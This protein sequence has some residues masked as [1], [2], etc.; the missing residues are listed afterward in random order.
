MVTISFFYD[1]AHLV[2]KALDDI[3]EYRIWVLRN[4]KKGNRPLP[5]YLYTE[6]SRYEG[7]TPQSL[8]HSPYLKKFGVETKLKKP[9][10]EPRIIEEGY[11]T[12]D[13][14][15]QSG[16]EKELLVLAEKLKPELYKID[17]IIVEY[18]R[19]I[20]HERQESDLK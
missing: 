19:G 17:L 4:D 20:S 13:R 12:S 3:N 18:I 6:K 9:L 14:H 1:A 11:S 15:T 7:E 16:E 2:Q 8:G 5:K 10:G